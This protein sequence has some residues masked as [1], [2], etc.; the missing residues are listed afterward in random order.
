MAALSRVRSLNET[1]DKRAPSLELQRLVERELAE[2]LR[3]TFQVI[4]NL[5]RPE[6]PKIQIFD[7]FRFIVIASNHS[8][9]P[10]RELK[11]VVARTDLTEFSPVSIELDRLECGESR[12]I[13][14]IESRIVR[15]PDAT[16]LR[17]QIGVISASAFA[18]LSAIEFTEWDKPIVPSRSVEL[19]R[20]MLATSESATQIDRSPRAHDLEAR[21]D[22]GSLR[23]QI[24]GETIPLKRR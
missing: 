20:E 2:G 7:Q 12:T 11:G 10:I 17:D 16:F 13:A 5:T 18:D 4:A 19:T 22:R 24:W 8:A 6:A 21:D 9:I 1:M 14:T 23:E 3:Y 15:E